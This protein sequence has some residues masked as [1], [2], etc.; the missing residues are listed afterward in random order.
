MSGFSTSQLLSGKYSISSKASGHFREL[1]TNKADPA[2][3]PLNTQRPI[4]Y[5]ITS[6]H[7]TQETIPDSGDFS[8]IL[9]TVAAAVAAQVDIIQIREKRLNA[10][11]LYE[12]ALK[13]AALVKGSQTR[14]LVNDRADIASAAQADG[15]HLTTRSIQ[16]SVIRKTFREEFLIGVSTHNLTEVCNA[17]SEGADFV[18]F[19]PVFHT[20]SK[21]LFGEPVGLES[22]QQVAAHVRPL[23]VLALGGV[24]LD[25]VSDCF[26]AGAAGIA[27]ISLFR[28]EDR[29]PILVA[30]IR[31]LFR[32]QRQ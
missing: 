19:G 7:T 25:R 26:R 17:Q 9:T 24:S 1:V 29:L 6:G 11:V 4:I 20:A 18:V 21:E 31:R 32:E 22:L 10:R 8:Q 13:A 15:V 28:Q 30:E 14:L 12:L 23:P 16:T 3:M 27:A 5:L 2:R